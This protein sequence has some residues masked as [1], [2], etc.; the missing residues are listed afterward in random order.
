MFQTRGKCRFQTAFSRGVSVNLEIDPRQ[1]E[2]RNQSGD[3]SHPGLVK[4]KSGHRRSGCEDTSLHSNSDMAGN[5]DRSTF[6]EDS[7]PDRKGIVRKKIKDAGWDQPTRHKL[8][9]EP[10]YEGLECGARMHVQNTLVSTEDYVTGTTLDWEHSE[11]A[12]LCPEVLD[13]SSEDDCDHAG[14]YFC[15]P[16]AY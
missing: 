14:A 11:G 7:S 10:V 13:F 16:D 8:Q 9:G 4:S 3:A 1:L 5:I 6:A 12:Q 2:G 15:I